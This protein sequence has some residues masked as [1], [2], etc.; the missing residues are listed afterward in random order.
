MFLPVVLKGSSD[1]GGSKSAPGIFSVLRYFCT[2]ILNVFETQM[3][4][5]IPNHLGSS[6]LISSVFLLSFKNYKLE[7]YAAFCWQSVSAI[8]VGYRALPLPDPVVNS[9]ECNS[10]FFFFNIKLQNGGLKDS[11]SQVYYFEQ[12]C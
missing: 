1:H 5:L 8:Y 7:V 4:F 3:Y 11:Y 9:K 2:T 6:A 10:F 12:D